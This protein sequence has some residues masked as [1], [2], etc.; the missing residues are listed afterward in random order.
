MFILVRQSIEP[1]SQHPRTARADIFREESFSHTPVN[2]QPPAG[3]TQHWI[4]FSA[5]WINTATD[6]IQGREEQYLCRSHADT[7]IVIEPT[8][9]RKI[10]YTRVWN[11]EQKES[12]S[13]EVSARETHNTFRTPSPACTATSAAL[14]DTKK[15]RGNSRWRITPQLT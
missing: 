2:T 7:D 4:D 12:K 8:W 13:K 15:Y 14:T 10:K 1:S 6:T 11:T 5:Q 3:R 9:T